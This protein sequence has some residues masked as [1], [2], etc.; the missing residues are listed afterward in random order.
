MSLDILGIP[1]KSATETKSLLREE[2][3]AGMFIV[4]STY[5]AKAGEEDAII[6]LHEDWQRSRGRKAKVCLSWELLRKVQAPSEF[7]AIARY[8]SEEMAQ[9]AIDDL[10]WDAWYDRLKSLVDEGPVTISCTGEWRLY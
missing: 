4:V 5:R 2:R 1:N 8:A 7:I 10:E 3:K 9:A 6:A